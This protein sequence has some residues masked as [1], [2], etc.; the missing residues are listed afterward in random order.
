MQKS[1]RYQKPKQGPPEL[2][3]PESLQS[4]PPR[5]AAFMLREP[6]TLPPWRTNRPPEGTDDGAWCG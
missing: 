6:R 5:I 2:L 1:W 3:A 4:M